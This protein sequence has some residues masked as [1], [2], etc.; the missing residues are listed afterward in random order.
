MSGISVSSARST[1]SRSIATV[2]TAIT[3]RRTLA[4]CAFV[5]RRKP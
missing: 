5:H 2:V 3:A 4:V 1:E